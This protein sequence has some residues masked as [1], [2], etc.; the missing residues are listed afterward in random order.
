VSPGHADGRRRRRES[1]RRIDRER[2]RERERRE[3]VRNKALW[4]KEKQERS[5]KAGESSR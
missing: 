3:V 5:N 4:M 2:E 1:S